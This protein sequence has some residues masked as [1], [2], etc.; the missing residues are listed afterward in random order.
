MLIRM[1]NSVAGPGFTYRRGE[2]VEVPSDRAEDL[3]AAGHAEM[4]RRVEDAKKP[5]GEK[6]VHPASTRKRRS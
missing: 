1:L 4:A 6:A 5:A 3:L 2:E